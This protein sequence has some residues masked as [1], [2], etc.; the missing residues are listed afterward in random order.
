MLKIQSRIWGTWLAPLVKC[1]NSRFQLSSRARGHETGPAVGLLL[2]VESAACPSAAPAPP[3][4]LALSSKYIKSLR[5]IQ[6]S[7]SP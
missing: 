4:E 2:T 5:N 6:S 1:P 3:P 7:V